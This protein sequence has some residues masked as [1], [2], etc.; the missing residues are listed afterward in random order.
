MLKIFYF[1]KYYQEL[2]VPVNSN[3]DVI[4]EAFIKLAKKYH[5]DSSSPEANI[6]KFCIIENAFR[7]LSSHNKVK[8]SLEEIEK[9]VHDIKVRHIQK[10]RDL[11]GHISPSV[12][13][14]DSSPFS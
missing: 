4:H 1:Q 14:E 9:V 11:K 8:N 6:D 7:V 13:S 2:N 10:P 5:P 12:L 3:Q